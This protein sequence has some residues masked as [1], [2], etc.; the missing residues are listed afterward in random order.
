MGV[1][2]GP[3]TSICSCWPGAP[4]QPPRLMR[5]RTDLPLP[6][7]N[8][9][10]HLTRSGTTN[11]NPTSTSTGWRTTTARAPS[12]RWRLRTLTGKLWEATR[13]TSLTAGSRWSTTRLTRMAWCT[14]SST[15]VSPATP[16]P[17]Q[18]VTA[19]TRD[20]ERTQDPSQEDTAPL[21]RH[22]CTCPRR[23]ERQEQL[24]DLLYLFY[25]QEFK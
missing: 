20:Q 13:S 21:H 10:L 5:L 8:P 24:C 16:H 22:R 9:N 15:R 25:K 1:W 2:R 4:W 18:V 23:A 17:H 14:T 11:L 3:C 6:S 19:R 12:T 7:T